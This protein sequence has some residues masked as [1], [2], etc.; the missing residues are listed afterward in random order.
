MLKREFVSKILQRPTDKVY[1][2][3]KMFLQIIKDY[4]ILESY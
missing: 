3:L 2:I 1:P 4:L